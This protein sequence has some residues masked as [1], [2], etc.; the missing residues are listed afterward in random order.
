VVFQRKLLLIIKLKTG[1]FMKWLFIALISTSLFANE[2]R[3]NLVDDFY[4]QKTLAS[5]IKNDCGQCYPGPERGSCLKEF[6]SRLSTFGCDETIEI[7]NVTRACSGNYGS[8]CLARGCRNLSSFQCDEFIE[9][10]E[11]T[12]ACRNVYDSKCFDFFASKIPE[13]QLDERIEVVQV[14]TQC[15]NVSPDVLECTKYTC[16][17]LSPFACDEA[18]EISNILKSCGR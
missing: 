6:C 1:V 16:S 11:I 5:I 2:S 8:E 4:S 18:H 7:Q 15:K 14:I 12:N 9:L 17:R 13:F 10:A 3:Q